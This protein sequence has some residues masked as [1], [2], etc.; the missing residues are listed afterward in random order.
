MVVNCSKHL[1]EMKKKQK[2]KIRIRKKEIRK[3]LE[4]RERERENIYFK[5]NENIFK[6]KL[7]M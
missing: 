1:P 4:I 7:I 6:T 5:I 2:K 3:S